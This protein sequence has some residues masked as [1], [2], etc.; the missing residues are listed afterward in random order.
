MKN[1]QTNQ[2][3]EINISDI[4][5]LHGNS[6]GMLLAGVVLTSVFET[7]PPPQRHR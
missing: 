4:Y 2:H 7:P 6:A 3:L 1:R 5:C